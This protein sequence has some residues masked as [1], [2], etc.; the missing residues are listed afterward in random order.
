MNFDTIILFD[1]A[2]HQNLWPLNFTKPIAE[3]RLSYHT[4]KELWHLISGHQP[5]C[6]ASPYLNKKYPTAFGS[7]NLY[8]NAAALPSENLWSKIKELKDATSLVQNNRV[9]ASCSTAEF[10]IAN[11]LETKVENA[12]NYSGEVDWLNRPA[13][14]F[15]LASR[16]IQMD[17]D[18]IDKS[19]YLTNDKLNNPNNLVVEPGNCFVHP[20]AT[21]NG[22]IINAQKGPVI[23][24]SDVLIMEGAMLR[25]PL[26]ICNNAVVKMGAKIYGPTTI[27]PFCKVGG[28]I[29]NSVFQAYSNKGHDGYLGNSVIGEWCNLG[30]D[31]N[32]SNLKNNYGRIKT[33]SYL[34]NNFTDSGEQFH[35]LV[36]GDHTKC[37][38]NTMFNTGTTTGVFANVFGS[39]FPPKFIP[40]FSWGQNQVYQLEKALE[41]AERVMQRKNINLE[42]V[43]IAILK[44]IYQITE[45]YR[46]KYL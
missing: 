32:C 34:N 45:P 21:L 35:G 30:A 17:V 29:T 25:G 38:I 41:T 19:P 23:I 22:V 33:W 12:I 36:M 40:S 14:F 26:A 11:A 7:N 16:Y 8:L 37:S 31:S 18:L 13:G 20:T 39:G 2:L 44:H 24:G 42:E 28:E 5:T 4:I 6:L 46:N 3:L 27:G 9:I 15:K 43:D 10:E 1:D